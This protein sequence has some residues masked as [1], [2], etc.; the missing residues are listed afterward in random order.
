MVLQQLMLLLLLAPGVGRSASGPARSSLH[1]Q[2]AAVPQADWHSQLL[3]LTDA[4]VIAVTA[5]A[6]A[7]AATVVSTTAAA[8]RVSRG[9]SGPA[10]CSWHECHSLLLSPLLPLLLLLPLLPGF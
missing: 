3:S 5:T 4:A 8:V 9:D 2:L 1:E 10:L 6:T 7:A